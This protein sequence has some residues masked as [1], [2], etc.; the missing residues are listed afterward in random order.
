MGDL[1]VYLNHKGKNICFQRFNCG[2]FYNNS[3]M[4]II[5]LL[6]DFAIGKVQESRKAGMI[7]LEINIKK[8]DFFT[9]EDANSSFHSSK[10][11]I[12][13][14]D[15]NYHNNLNN[16]KLNINNKAY[17]VVVNVYQSRY[18]MAGDN[19]GTSDPY[20]KIKLND[21]ILKTKIKN[22]TVNPV[23]KFLI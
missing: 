19:D 16:N 5:K 9:H 11:E 15:P 18:L 3:E 10:N 13:I 17:I 6:P 7:K 8:N 20:M 23:N 4:M 22:D 21:Q 1:Y 14:A 2:T 12:Q